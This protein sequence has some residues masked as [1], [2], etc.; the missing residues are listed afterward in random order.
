[1]MMIIIIM[2]MMM[3]DDDASS[4]LETFAR[5]RTGTERQ[6]PLLIVI[7]VAEIQNLGKCL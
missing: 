7:Y 4:E 3:I 6:L 1:M 5:W 2:I